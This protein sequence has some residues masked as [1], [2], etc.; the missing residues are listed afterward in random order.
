VL[1]Q[2]GGDPVPDERRNRRARLVGQFVELAGLV[3][4]DAD[5]QDP[6]LGRLLLALGI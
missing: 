1:G 6:I 3:G 2:A 4:A 5:R